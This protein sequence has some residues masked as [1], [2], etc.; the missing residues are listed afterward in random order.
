MAGKAPDQ[1]D[2]QIS[3]NSDENLHVKE[4]ETPSE[5][6]H[7]SSSETKEP[8]E[9]SD[10]EHTLTQVSGWLMKRTRISRKWKRRWFQ[11]KNTELCYGTSSEVWR[12]INYISM[13]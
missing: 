13:I 8:T 5:Y 10:D 11:L 2:V 7:E 9:V 6:G 1:A 12:D 4:G 3:V